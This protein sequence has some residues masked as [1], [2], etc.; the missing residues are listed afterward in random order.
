MNNNKTSESY[1]WALKHLFS[2][3]NSSEKFANKLLLKL[4]PTFLPRPLV[5]M[6]EYFILIFVITN[7]N[8]YLDSSHLNI[9]TLDTMFISFLSSICNGYKCT[10]KLLAFFLFYAFLAI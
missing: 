6:F 4:K 3:L 10:A 1:A 5:N 2:L 9:Y 7:L 8:L